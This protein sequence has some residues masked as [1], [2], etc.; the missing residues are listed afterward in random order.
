[1]VDQHRDKY[2]KCRMMAP[3]KHPN[4]ES[5]CYDV[6][7]GNVNTVFHC[8]NKGDCSQFLVT[9]GMTNLLQEGQQEIEKNEITRKELVKFEDVASIPYALDFDIPVVKVICGDLFTGMLTAEGTVWT[10]GYNT[11]G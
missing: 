4:F 9:C 1:M 5:L 7:P 8:V 3:V 10:Q 11:Y 2:S 6:V